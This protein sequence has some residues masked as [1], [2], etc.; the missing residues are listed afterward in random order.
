M[1]SAQMSVHR[2]QC[3]APAKAVNSLRLVLINRWS[4]N[5]LDYPV[6]GCVAKSLNHS[7][8]HEIIPN[9]CLKDQHFR[10]VFGLIGICLV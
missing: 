10:L 1:T 8:E 3:T 9:Y 4:I 5:F 7:T 6:Q 2:C